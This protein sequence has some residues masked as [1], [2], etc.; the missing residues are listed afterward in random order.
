MDYST[1]F[2]NY[3]CT[4]C[5]EVCP[6]GA[7]LPI[8][9]ENKK[10]IQLGKAKFIKENCVVFTENTDCGACSE[11]CPTKAVRMIPYIPENNPKKNLH[12][13][14]VRDEYCTG[15]G[16]CEHACPT[17]PYKSIYVEGNPVHLTAKKPPEEKIEQKI[18]YRED[19]P[20]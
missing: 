6:T 17:K 9:V 2:C 1:S 12:L 4:A 8:Q 7:I 5:A 16:A 15:C 20:F 13:P 3:E 10:L 18:D 14:E 19:F 11:H